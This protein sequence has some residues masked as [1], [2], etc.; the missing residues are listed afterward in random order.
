VAWAAAVLKEACS[1]WTQ[2]RRCVDEH[3]NR[4]A[5]PHPICLHAQ[6]R[7][8]MILLEHGLTI[9]ARRPSPVTQT[10]DDVVNGAS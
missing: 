2:N 1:G 5:H 4:L 10:E 3:G 8:Y 9:P 6:H 7:Y